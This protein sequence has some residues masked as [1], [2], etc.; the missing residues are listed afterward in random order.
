LAAN[1]GCKWGSR[2]ERHRERRVSARGGRGPQ[3]CVGDKAFQTPPASPENSPGLHPRGVLQHEDDASSSASSAPYSPALTAEHSGLLTPQPQTPPALAL[4]CSMHEAA[5][6]G[7]IRYHAAAGA[8]PLDKDM[9]WLRE[10]GQALEAVVDACLAV[11]KAAAGVYGEY[12]RA[13]MFKAEGG[14]GGLKKL[15]DHLFQAGYMMI[16]VEGP[17]DAG[18]LYVWVSKDF[19]VVD[20]GD[21][22]DLFRVA[23]LGGGVGDAEDA[24]GADANEYADGLQSDTQHHAAPRR[25]AVRDGPQDADI[26]N[27]ALPKILTLDFADPPPQNQRCG[28]VVVLKPSAEKSKTWLVE[29]SNKKDGSKQKDSI[30]GYWS[31]LEKGS[32]DDAAENPVRRTLD[33]KAVGKPLAQALARIDPPQRD[34]VRLQAFGRMDLEDTQKGELEKFKENADPDGSLLDEDLRRCSVRMKVTKKLHKMLDS[35]QEISRTAQGAAE[36][37]RKARAGSPAEA[38]AA[39]AELRLLSIAVFA[40][41]QTGALVCWDLA[42]EWRDAVMAR[43]AERRTRRCDV[44][45]GPAGRA[46]AERTDSLVRRCVQSCKRYFIL[47]LRCERLWVEVYFNPP[48]LSLPRELLH[49]PLWEFVSA[50]RK[51]NGKGGWD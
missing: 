2:V 27:R 16:A 42:R 43:D 28:H 12:G 21:A 17:H 31:A 38:G 4:N 5:A 25:A 34:R 29:D 19:Y 10:G 39:E 36:R 11:L 23:G 20:D 49:V 8:S 26:L 33:Q 6:A 40:K 22:L 18:T 30:K 44:E 50:A 35:V 1:G 48:L 15:V 24:H 13:A 37:S 3:A 7:R 47:A 51:E 14:T 9:P 41:L 46:R 32:H 45:S